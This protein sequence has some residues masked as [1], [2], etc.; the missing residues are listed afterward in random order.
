MPTA[1]GDAANAGA[2]EVLRGSSGGL[3]ATGSK[4]WT[5]DTAGVP[6]EVAADDRFGLT[7]SAGDFSRD[8]YADL[9]IGVRA[10]DIGH[11]PFEGIVQVLQGLLATNGLTTFRNQL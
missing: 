1:A 10:E 11:G 2:V 9:A 6:D 8:G 4:F 3:T 5:Q 7:L